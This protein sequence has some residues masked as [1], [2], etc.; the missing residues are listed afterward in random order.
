M[1][2]S[3]DDMD[4]IF[5]KACDRNNFTDIKNICSI[6]GFVLSQDLFNY[7]VIVSQ[8][9]DIVEFLSTHQNIDFDYTLKIAMFN[10]IQQR[11]NR[12]QECI[13]FLAKHPKTNPTCALL[14]YF[15]TCTKHFHFDTVLIEII[16]DCI[17]QKHL[18]DFF[19]HMSQLLD[20]KYSFAP[21]IFLEYYMK[22]IFY[23]SKTPFDKI[24]NYHKILQHGRHTKYFKEFEH[25]WS[26]LDTRVKLYYKLSEQINEDCVNVILNYM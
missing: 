14:Y 7:A 19:D 23:N 24:L 17:C 4:F 21:I 3:Q 6:K 18:V 1:L 9:K 26:L 25:L 16:F 8:N 5:K 12:L 13:L 22:C 2:L 20:S 10:F 15:N 11:N